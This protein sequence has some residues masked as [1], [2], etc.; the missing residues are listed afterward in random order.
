MGPRVN[1]LG[2]PIGA[3]VEHWQG[4]SLPVLA[5]M[6]GRYCR[7]EPLSPERHA[8]ELWT[9]LSADKSGA[10]WTY[11]PYGPFESEDAYRDWLRK[12][13]QQTDPLFF[14]IIDENSKQAVGVASYLRVDPNAGSIEVG[15]LHFSPMLQ[16]TPAAT[17]AMYLMMQHAFAQG[18]RR[19]EW[20]CDSLNAASRR[21]AQRLGLSFEGIFRQARVTKGRNRDTAWFAAIDSEWPLLEAAF[22]QWLSPENFDAQGLQRVALSTLTATISAKT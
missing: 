21:A 20:K 9:A 7:L 11:L 19:Y 5:V 3:A 13:E 2:Q 16:R 12:H 14:A 15:H 8:H 17:E 22:K 1:E 4:A 6:Q 18:Y 10:G